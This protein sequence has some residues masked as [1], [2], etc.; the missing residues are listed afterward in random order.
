VE[1]GRSI[2]MSLALENTHKGWGTAI[3]SRGKTLYSTG[4]TERP[5]EILWSPTRPDNA[6]GETRKGVPYDK[7]DLGSQRIPGS[8]G[9][10]RTGAAGA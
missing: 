5:R 10:D 9:H 1:F 6:R 2:G 7:E 8:C 3:L 4:Q